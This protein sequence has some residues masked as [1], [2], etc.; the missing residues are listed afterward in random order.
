VISS[1]HSFEVATMKHPRQLR[2]APIP[3]LATHRGLVLELAKREIF[4]R[5]RGANLGVAWAIFSPFLMLAV[6]TMAFGEIL[7]SRWPGVETTGAFV[8][9]LFIGLSIHSFFAE[10][11]TRAPALIFANANYVKKVVFPLE[12]LPW[13]VVLSALFHLALNI[14]VLLVGVWLVEGSVHATALLLPVVLLPL[15]P[16]VVGAMWLLS[17]V[18]TYVRDIAQVMPPAATAFLFL[19][20]A[21]VPVQAVPEK[22]RA[23]FHANPLTLIIDQARI[24]VLNGEGPN[25]LSLAVYTLVAL[26]FSVVSFAIFRRLRG[27][28]AD[29]L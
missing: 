13:P 11:I 21:I 22:Y 10:C 24:V 3:L 8:L 9:V 23:V 5:Y 2:A 19:S 17:A 4:G 18:G 7:G 6:Y 14:C 25:Y 15:L 1:A 29:V 28:F 27:G 12:I 20:S 26:G 16:V